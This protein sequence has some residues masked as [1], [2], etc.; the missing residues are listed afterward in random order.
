MQL[1]PLA[2]TVDIR[3][4]VE[5]LSTQAFEQWKAILLQTLGKD[6]EKEFYLTALT[7]MTNNYKEDTW[8]SLRDKTLAM[9]VA[10]SVKPVQ[11]QF[12][13][14]CAQIFPDDVKIKIGQFLCTDDSISFGCTCRSN[15]ILTESQNYIIN[16]RTPDSELVMTNS[17]IERMYFTN[18]VAYKHRFHQHLKVLRYHDNNCYKHFINSDFLSSTIPHLTELSLQV[19]MLE[20]LPL[21]QIFSN[22]H[23]MKYLKLY[24]DKDCEGLLTNLIEKLNSIEMKRKIN[25]LHLCHN[26][27]WKFSTQTVNKMCDLINFFLQNSKTEAI[28]FTTIKLIQIHTSSLFDGLFA[29]KVIQLHLD[30]STIIA[31]ESLVPEVSQNIEWSVKHLIITC[32]LTG[33]GEFVNRC[34]K[35][36]KMKVFS[37]VEDLDFRFRHIRSSAKRLDQLDPVLD[38]AIIS[39][40]W[41]RGLELPKLQHVTFAYGDFAD[42]RITAF[43]FDFLTQFRHSLSTKLAKLVCLDFKIESITSQDD[44]SFRVDDDVVE[45]FGVCEL[46]DEKAIMT[47]DTNKNAVMLVAKINR[48]G[49]AQI[50]ASVKDWCVNTNPFQQKQITL[51]LDRN[52]KPLSESNFDLC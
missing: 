25:F 8:R 49:L 23:E 9:G 38:D 20:K 51:L 33:L 37:S 16:T 30:C 31:L 45:R 4:R 27:R 12:P 13:Q 14:K 29:G 50:V 42:V 17:Q 1:S 5:S 35:L 3:S 47:W 44:P 6:S 28:R 41:N 46:L 52:S 40:I 18:A 32:K 22:L 7:M 11:T 48:K 26:E 2:N 15:F 21:Q 34:V 36:M 39:L 10:L 43:L 24:L 19:R